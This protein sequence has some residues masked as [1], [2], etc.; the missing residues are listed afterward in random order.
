LA[1]SHGA[2]YLPIGSNRGYGGA[3]NAA[4]ATLSADVRWVL[5]SNP[6]VVLQ[7]GAIDELIAAAEADQRIGSAGPS[8]LTAEGTVYPSA[9]AIPSLR[10][11]VGHALFVNLWAGNP[12]TRAYRREAEP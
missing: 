10:T 11:G 4:V 5:V 12:W 6:D 1:E 7:P 8:I 9:R 2:V 3:V